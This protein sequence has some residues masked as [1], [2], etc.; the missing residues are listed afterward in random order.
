MLP[1]LHSL[2]DLSFQQRFYLWI[3]QESVSVVDASATSAP[4]VH[5]CLPCFHL[6][7]FI[8]LCRFFDSFIS[9]TP[10]SLISRLL[11][12][13]KPGLLSV[14]SLLGPSCFGIVPPQAQRVAA[15]E[16]SGWRYFPRGW[17]WSP[18]PVAA[19]LPPVRARPQQGLLHQPAHHHICEVVTEILEIHPEEMN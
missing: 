5:L 17:S 10:S 12:L 3:V 7:T 11:T 18:L 15:V 4:L 9:L 6:P 16:D 19:H 13:P 8:L 14:S 2:E 1:F